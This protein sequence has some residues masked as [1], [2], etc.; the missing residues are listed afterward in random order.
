[1]V[2]FCSDLDRARD[3]HRGCGCALAHRLVGR[4]RLRPVEMSTSDGVLS[5]ASHVERRD[6]Q[7]AIE[8]TEVILAP[9]GQ[10]ATFGHTSFRFYL[11]SELMDR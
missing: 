4:R 1:M 7:Y 9:E 5:S 8:N 6:F 10:I 11:I 3:F 2:T